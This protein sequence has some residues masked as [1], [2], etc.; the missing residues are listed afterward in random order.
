MIFNNSK[1]T[2]YYTQRNNKKRPASAC[3]VTAATQACMI[4]DNKF[5]HP[6]G[7][8]PEDFLMELLETKEA[9]S[10]LNT[11]L[12]GALCNP[13][14]TSHCI[15]WAVNK[16]VGQRVCKVETITL[17]EMI[18]HIYYGGSV[19]VGGK[20]TQSGHFVCIVGLETDQDID[21]VRSPFDIDISKIKNIIVDDPWGDYMKNYKCT[22]GNDV[23]VPISVFINLIFGKNKVKTSQVY[24]RA[25]VA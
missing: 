6:E 15:A 23:F 3:N 1:K 20:F 7:M 10:L 16:A 5:P 17:Q 8:Q 25:E 21:T 12:P 19:V 4:T 22:N 24:Y 18:Y 13:W 11:V 14:N 2:P 9:W